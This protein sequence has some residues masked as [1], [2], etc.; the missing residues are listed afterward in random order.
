MKT[1][2]KVLLWVAVSLVVVFVVLWL[3]VLISGQFD[4][5][6]GLIRYLIAQFQGGV[7]YL[8]VSG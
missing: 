1:F 3:T 8:G 6:P 4:G 2:L 5:I 7:L